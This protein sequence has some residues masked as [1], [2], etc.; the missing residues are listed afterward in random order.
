MK[1]FVVGVLAVV[2]VVVIPNSHSHKIIYG[3]ICFIFCVCFK[4]NFS[5][6]DLPWSS[7]SLMQLLCSLQTAVTAVEISNINIF[8]FSFIQ[9]TSRDRQRLKIQWLQWFPE[10]RAISKKSGKKQNDWGIYSAF[11]VR[12]VLWREASGI[13]RD[14][15]VLR[16]ESPLTRFSASQHQ[17]KI[18]GGTKVFRLTNITK[19]KSQNHFITRSQVIYF[20]YSLP[21]GRKEIF[22]LNT[23]Q[24]K[25]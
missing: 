14:W 24:G 4:C 9:E 11:I 15:W 22:I 2:V 5:V 8:M 13:E 7:H 17:N 20:S 21:Q 3:G 25:M 23:R 19:S 6:S 16:F 10:V 12:T 18:S 1:F